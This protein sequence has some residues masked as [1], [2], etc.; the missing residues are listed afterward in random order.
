MIC[1]SGVSVTAV[2]AGSILVPVLDASYQAFFSWKCLPT[3]EAS[4]PGIL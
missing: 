2:L 1:Y 4:V 3:K